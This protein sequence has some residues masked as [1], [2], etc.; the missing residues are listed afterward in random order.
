MTFIQDNPVLSSLLISLVI[1]MTFFFFA[2]LFKTDK[3]TDFSYSLTFFIL[4][5]ILLFSDD[6]KISSGK[7]VLAAAILLW[8]LRLGSYLF[9]RILKIGKD[10][11]FDD[12]RGHFFVFLR[13]WLLQTITVWIV[14]LPF[15]LTLTRGNAAFTLASTVAGLSLFI[16]GLVI[17]T[18][19]DLQKFRFKLNPENR[20]RWIDTGLWAYSRHPNY[21]G[22]IVLWWGLFIMVLPN[23][24]GWNLLSVLGPVFITLLLLFVSGIPLLEKSAEKKYRDNPEYRSYRDSTSL[25]LLL[26]RKNR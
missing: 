26:P 20:D 17:E 4:T 3:V 21:F 11:R 10:D 25:L 5:L 8:A 14:M 24:S 13:F 6:F 1:N 15:S 2:S 19:S 9:Y 18:L 12:K 23:L 7:I 22:E 16:I